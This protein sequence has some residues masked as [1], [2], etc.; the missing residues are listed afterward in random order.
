MPTTTEPTMTQ[1]PAT[2]LT[3][4]AKAVAM[5]TFFANLP[6]SRIKVA[7][8]YDRLMAGANEDVDA[9]PEVLAGYP[10]WHP[11]AGIDAGELSTNIQCLAHDAQALALESQQ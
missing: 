5:R 6:N 2:N 4:G 8:A 9:D 11:V 1:T 7:D 3:A 10:L